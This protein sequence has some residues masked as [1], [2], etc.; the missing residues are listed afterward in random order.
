M[1]SLFRSFRKPSHVAVAISLD[2][3]DQ[4]F[5]D[6]RPKTGLTEAHGVKAQF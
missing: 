2:K 6:L 3:F 1:T 5:P 4:S